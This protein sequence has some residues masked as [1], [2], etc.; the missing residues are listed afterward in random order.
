[1]APDIPK[2]FGRY[3]VT[4]RI[5]VGSMAEI[6]RVRQDGLGGFSRTYA[7]K[8]ILPQLADDPQMVALMEEEARVGGKLSHANIV[9]VREP[10]HEGRRLY[11]VK[12]HVPGS[13]LA[14]ALEACAGQGRTIPVPH[15]V[16]ILL[17][18]LK[19]LDYAHTRRVRQGGRTVEL[20][21]VHRDLS[22]R[23]VLLSLRGEV[24]I[25][26]FGVGR[27][28]L[29]RRSVGLIDYI[30]PE[31]S[32]GGRATVRSDL[33]SCGV[34]LY[35]MLTGV[36]PFRRRTDA[37]TRA[38]IRQA[39]ADPPRSR[40]PDIPATLDAVVRRALAL[41]PAQRFRSAGEMKES[42][43]AFFHDEGFIFG[44]ANLA[45]FLG[46][47]ADGPGANG[48][49]ERP[50]D[51]P[52]E[53]AHADRPT[54]AS[55]PAGPP[56]PLGG[57]ETSIRRIPSPPRRAEARGR[58][59]DNLNDMAHAPR[60]QRDGDE[61]TLIRSNPLLLDDAKAWDDAPTR[62][63]QSLTDEELLLPEPE[64]EPE[65]SRLAP[66]SAPPP[67]E[68]PPERPTVPPDRGTRIDPVP[69]P[70]SRPRAAAPAASPRPTAAPLQPG[71]LVV[72]GALLTAT[73]LA[74]GLGVGLWLGRSNPAKAPEA[75]NVVTPEGATLSQDGAPVAGSPPFL[76]P[77]ASDAE[78]T[79]TTADG[80][81]HHVQVEGGAVTGVT[82][83]AQ[84]L[85]G[86][87]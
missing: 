21:V 51:D 33:F 85:G 84:P 12:E 25:T 3:R 81:E 82:L 72:V 30:S 48:G 58:L 41:D 4:D 63:R 62:I 73:A 57:A 56:E 66:V 77:A 35:E 52:V 59:L 36:H 29:G 11:I 10:G 80:Q 23:N 32:T 2:S 75:I 6:Y 46:T 64:P 26:N 74:M 1:M 44:Q 43:D 40:N 47:L 60:L 55:E 68:P 49:P 13:D 61:S 65:P 34:L 8:A 67:P 5:A 70:T 87:P 24:K 7:V 69:S 28:Q 71:V 38:A 45:D 22:P 86:R 19:A 78:W 9:Q 14:R 31:Q 16:F 18:V 17:E 54:D 27:H 83:G 20:Q 50:A 76:L 53:D 37:H 42:L 39:Q 15:A 79:I